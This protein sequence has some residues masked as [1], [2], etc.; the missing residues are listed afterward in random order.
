MSAPKILSI[1][2]AVHVN[3]LVRLSLAAIH[4]NLLDVIVLLDWFLI[5]FQT[6]KVLKIRA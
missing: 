2:I 1:T 5:H 6:R 3:R 4:A